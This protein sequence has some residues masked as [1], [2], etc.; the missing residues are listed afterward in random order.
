MR[1]H[2]GYPCSP[3]RQPG[4]LLEEACL[5][6]VKFREVLFQ[7]FQDLGSQLAGIWEDPEPPC[8][9][10]FLEAIETLNSF[11]LILD[12]QEYLC[13]PEIQPGFHFFHTSCN[14]GANVAR[15]WTKL[16]ISLPP[17]VCWAPGKCWNFLVSLVLGDEKALKL[18]FPGFRNV[19][20]TPDPLKHSLV[21]IL[22]NFL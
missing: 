22:T 10:S 14:P 12:C 20:S 1:Y 5:P 17:C 3:E 7:I 2:G 9:G 8:G 19:G 21:S 15:C 4:F 18:F 16:T 13:F 11:S 6:R